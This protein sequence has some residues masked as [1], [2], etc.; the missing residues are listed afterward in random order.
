MTI[1]MA[2]CGHCVDIPQSMR[3]KKKAVDK[4]CLSS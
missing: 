3:K 1:R 2:S 4:Q